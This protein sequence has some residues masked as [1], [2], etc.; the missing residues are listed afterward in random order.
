MVK[1]VDKPIRLYAISIFIVL[2]YGLLPLCS[3]FP[4]GYWVVLV[5]P[6]FLPFN[7][8]VLALYGPDGDVSM[9]LLVI[10]LALSFLSVGS[11]VVTF[12]GVAEAR[13]ATL[14]LLTLD[15][16]W[17]FF[18]VIIAVMDASSD[19]GDRIELVGQ[20]IF[21]PVWLGVVWWNLT[22]PDISSWLKYMSE[23]NS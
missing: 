4:A 17:W 13:I 5:G 14:I 9:I 12:L 23:V 1:L 19:A 6:R 21:P 16:A 7:G 15:V 22:R 18:L 10:T 3:Y 11:S 2:A 20:L 8:S